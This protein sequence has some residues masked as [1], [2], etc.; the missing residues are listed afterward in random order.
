MGSNELL[1]SHVDLI[2]W[3]HDDETGGL[4]HMLHSDDAVLKSELRQ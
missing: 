2:T 4:V 1:T 3:E